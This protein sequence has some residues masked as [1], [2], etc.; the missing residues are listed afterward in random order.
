MTHARVGGAVR[1]N[2]RRINIASAT[3]GRALPCT[4]VTATLEAAQLREIKFPEMEAVTI[5][6]RLTTPGLQPGHSGPTLAHMAAIGIAT[7]CTCL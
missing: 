6:G 2:P 3:Y 7:S 4:R 5:S 1:T